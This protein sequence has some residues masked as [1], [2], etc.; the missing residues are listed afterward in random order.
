MLLFANQA[1]CAESVEVLVSGYVWQFSFP[2]FQPVFR[3]K[4]VLQSGQD[5]VSEAEAGK[6]C[7]ETTN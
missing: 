6:P 2:I 5:A 3:K 1:S 7:R 4:S